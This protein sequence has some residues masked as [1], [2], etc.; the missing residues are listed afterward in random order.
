MEQGHVTAT[1]RLP[2]PSTVTI[3]EPETAP[4]TVSLQTAGLPVGAAA[5][6]ETAIPEVPAAMETH[7]VAGGQP[8]VQPTVGQIPEPGS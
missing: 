2:R 8:V 7:V 3:P 5:P 6:T 1:R 4:F